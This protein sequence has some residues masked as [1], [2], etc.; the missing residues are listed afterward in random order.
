MKN[1]V[2][3]QSFYINSDEEEENE[4]GKDEEDGN[5]SESSNDSNDNSRQQSRPNS[6]NTTWPQSYRYAFFGCLLALCDNSSFAAA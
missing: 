1:S 5:V 2:S 6:L 3:D 4:S